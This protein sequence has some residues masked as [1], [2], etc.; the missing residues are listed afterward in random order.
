MAHP[1]QIRVVE[2]CVNQLLGLK[3]VNSVLEVGSWS[4]HG[5]DFRYLFPLATY[6]GIDVCEGVGVD[7]VC[8]GEDASFQSNYFDLVLSTECF[9]HNRHWRETFANMIRMCKPGGAIVVTCAGLGRPEHGTS[10]TSKS[11]SLTSAVL[12]DDYYS[13]LSSC[14]FIKTGL[15]GSLQE[16]VFSS[17]PESCDLYFVGVKKSDVSSEKVLPS[18]ASSLLR[19]ASLTVNSPTPALSRVKNSLRY[20]LLTSVER[21]L[22]ER[23]YHSLR[24]L[25][26]RSGFSFSS[27]LSSVKS[28]FH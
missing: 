19:A 21:L 14:D 7:L 3:M 4:G 15:L 2:A 12:G 25:H 27:P 11:A 23:R 5:G 17:N 24:F 10:R 1:Q 8:K 16:F 26:Q 20:V 13:N 9:E 28:L 22:G 18:N 6:T